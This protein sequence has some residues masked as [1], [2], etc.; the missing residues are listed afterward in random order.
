MRSI[1][2]EA[3]P[4]ASDH[5]YQGGLDSR[6]GLFNDGLL[7]SASDL[8]TYDDTP[9]TSDSALDEPGTRAEEI[10]FQ[11]RLCH[12][13]PNGG[14]VP[15]S[16]PYNDIDAAI[17]AFFDMHISYL[18]ADYS[19]EVLAKWKATSYED[20]TGYDYIQAH[21]GYRYV[22]QASSLTFHPIT[23]DLATLSLTIGNEG[24]AP[25][26]RKFDTTI[27][28]TNTET[29]ESFTLETDIDNR[30]ITS[31]DASLFKVDLDIRTW[32]SGTYELSLSMTDSVTELP[33]HFAHAGFENSTSLPI[34]TLHM[35]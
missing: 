31:S 23:T 11:N 19:A 2:N 4:L 6:L 25:A 9:L 1:L 5:A 35:D 28:V 21:L 18:N 24:F 16:S 10:R 26:Y 27:T 3:E 32:E 34:G 33:I 22:L 30:G 7:G 12:Y 29:G 20:G 17:Q 15:A 13:V 8:G 14:E